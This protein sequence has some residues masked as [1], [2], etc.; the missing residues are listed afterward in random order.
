MARRRWRGYADFEMPSDG[1]KEALM[2]VCPGNPDQEGRR[3]RALMEA[4]GAKLDRLY[5]VNANDL[6]YHNL[7]RFLPK[8]EAKSFASYRGECWLRDHQPAI[9]EYMAG[10]C[11]VIPM[12][13]I[14][15]KEPTYEERIQLIHDIYN[16][17]NNPVTSWFDYSADLDIESRSARRAKDG[18]IIEP[19]AIKES[20]LAYLCDEYAMRSIMWKQFGLEEV[21]LGLA[22]TQH[23][24]FQV[25]NQKPEID[26]TIP[27]VRAVTLQEIKMVHVR[28]TGAA[29][30]ANDQPVPEH[31]RDLGMV[32]KS[33]SVTG[34]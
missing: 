5:I 8:N 32:L 10:R 18:V 20:S 17:G 3:F 25:E 31:A 4:A 7:K 9:D 14:V 27:K 24:L 6:G 15:G 11:E 22:V 33:S 30:P 21:Y 16:R 29:V 2:T 19:W 26:L 23:D 12:S 1:R 13:E 28:E 34:T